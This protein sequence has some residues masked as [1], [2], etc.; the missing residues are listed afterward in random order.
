MAFLEPFLRPPDFAPPTL[1][2][3][4]FA[5]CFSAFGAIVAMRPWTGNRVVCGRKDCSCKR[6]LESAG[7][8]PSR[9]PEH[10]ID[11]MMIGLLYRTIPHECRLDSHPAE[12][13][14]L[15]P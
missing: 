14:A 3:D 5:G 6:L 2:T 12:T 15:A 9:I 8:A 4:F 7:S 11:L 13:K 10:L 1:D